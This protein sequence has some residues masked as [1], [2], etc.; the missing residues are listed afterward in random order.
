MIGRVL[1]RMVACDTASH[2]WAN[3]NTYC[4]ANQSQGVSIENHVSKVKKNYL[5]MNKYLFKVKNIVDRLASVGHT[6][7]SPDH[8]K[9]IFN[10][11]G[12]RHLH[13]LCQIKI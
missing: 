10:P 6:V 3:L 4:H 7:T 11:R 1:T 5:S 12:T 2:M 13:F 8:V 9:A